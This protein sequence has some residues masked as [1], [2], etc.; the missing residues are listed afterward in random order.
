[1]FY[2]VDR[3]PINVTKKDFVVY[4][5]GLKKGAYTTLSSDNFKAR[6]VTSLSPDQIMFIKTN[7]KKLALEHNF[8]MLRQEFVSPWQKRKQN[9]IIISKYRK[10]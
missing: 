7:F 9:I 4:V 1:M 2:D 10:E 3:T 6:K 5:E 8:D